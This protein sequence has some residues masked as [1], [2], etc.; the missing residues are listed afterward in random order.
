VISE[1]S[2]ISSSAQILHCVQDDN[3]LDAAFSWTAC[4]F[5]W[6]GKGLR[7]AEHW[8]GVYFSVDAGIWLI[9]HIYSFDAWGEKPP[10]YWKGS[11]VKKR[12]EQKKREKGQ[13][14]VQ[15]GRRKMPKVPPA[16]SKLWPEQYRGKRWKSVYAI[17]F[18][19]RCQLCAYSCPLPKSRR[20]R[21]KWLGV[22]RLLLCTNHPSEPG[23]LREVLP[24]D[25]C[26]NFKAKRWQRP[27]TKSGGR[28]PRPPA[29]PK[30]EEVRRI[31]L[32]RGLF[33]L[34]DAADYDEVSKY[35]WRAKRRGA[36]VYASCVKKGRT[37]YMHRMIMR[38]RKGYVVDH[39]DGN[40]LNN[41]R[42][43]LRVCT[44]QQN[45][46]NRRPYGGASEFVGV[47][48][49]KGKWMAGIQYRGKYFY[50]GRF[51]DEVEAAKARDRKAYELHGEYAYLN[52]PED[53]DR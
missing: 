33:A 49:N 16:D 43:N 37:V 18:A 14:R 6:Q 2:D 9:Y 15:R 13:G 21:D 45:Q 5:S 10:Y 34:V 27:R 23:E 46:A 17:L 7:Y 12:A 39:I 50:L 4:P 53:F 28:R 25:T 52:F 1:K 26:R 31:P 48:R 47:V 38:P 19:G 41:R 22:T 30:D 51:D 29:N 36:K 24:I 44:H 11:I 32:G 42:C 20:L 3:D 8:Y 40:G 35:K